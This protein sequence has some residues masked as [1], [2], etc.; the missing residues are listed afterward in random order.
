MSKHFLEYGD[1]ELAYL[2]SKDKRLA[3]AIETIGFVEREVHTDVFESLIDSIVSQQISG[4]AAHTVW[5][6]MIAGLGAITPES[7]ASASIDELQQFGMTFNKARYIQNAGEKVARGALDLEALREKTDEE[8]CRELVAL[9]GIGV[10]TAEML[11]IFSLER[12]DVLS[13]GDL[14]IHK[15]MRMVHHHRK[16]PRDLFEKYRRR[17]SPYC[18][19]ASV[20]FW[21]VAGGA[22]EGMKDY[23]PKNPQKK[24]PAK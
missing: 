12:K 21:A 5:T 9:D 6:R 23:A 17:Y 1:E 3:E 11:M 19:V 4:K 24:A 8:V 13:F 18:S 16:I 14:G 10:W 7:I 15:G 2:K 22:I 20:Y